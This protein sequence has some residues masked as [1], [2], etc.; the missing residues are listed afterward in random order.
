[1]DI[2]MGSVGASVLNCECQQG[3]SVIRQALS[4]I[5]LMYRT[6]L[7]IQGIPVEW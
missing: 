3:L 1:M 5:R 7:S 4:V 6:M 2:H